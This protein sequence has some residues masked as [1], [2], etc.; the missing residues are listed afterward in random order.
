MQK[1][2]ITQKL[3]QVIRKWQAWADEIP[4]PFGQMSW[5][6]AFYQKITKQLRDEI[7]VQHCCFGTESVH[8]PSRYIVEISED[9]GL[10]FQ[11]EKF[12]LFLSA[13]N[14]F[15]AGEF[16]RLGVDP[17]ETEVQIVA[18]PT[19]KT[20]EIKIQS[21]WRECYS[22]PVIHFND[23]SSE[24]YEIEDSETIIAP[25]FWKEEAETP[26]VVRKKI[27]SLDIWREGDYQSKIPIF[28]PK[29]KIGRSVQEDLAL[30]DDETISRHHLELIYQGD[31]S[32]KIVMQGQ[33]PIFVGEIP[34]F[35]GQ[36]EVC[37]FG[38]V[39]EIG[40]Y[41]IKIQN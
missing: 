1:E 17:L 23:R 29:L 13:L 20:G 32:F 21:F 33:N 22:P 39:F 31:D 7:E 16:R 27:F 26:T 11:G 9:D 38:D 2:N 12:E 10:H 40:R 37:K 28:Q 3:H 30:L 14:R 8:L 34:L 5:S 15:L 24:H 25:S 4:S 36:T 19:L 6:D 35:T 18:A 41:S